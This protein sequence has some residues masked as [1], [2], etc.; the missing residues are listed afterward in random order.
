[1]VAW[2]PGIP[3][4]KESV[5]MHVFTAYPKADRAGLL[6]R[7]RAKIVYFDRQTSHTLTN[8]EILL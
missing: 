5:R 2:V 8:E 4:Y 7:R 3:G 1:M 6:L